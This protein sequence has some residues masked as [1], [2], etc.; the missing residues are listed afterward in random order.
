MKLINTLFVFS[1]IGLAIATTS[2]KK[3]EGP[4][5]KAQ[6]YGTVTYENGATGKVDEAPGAIIKIKYGAKESS[7][8]FDQMY[9]AFSDGSYN[10]RGLVPGDYYLTAE[11][12]DK[13]SFKHTHSGFVV[14]LNSRRSYVNVDFKLK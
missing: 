3:D 4:L 6:I 8:D 5:G 1:L 9:V 13:Y 2:C 12:I 10:I 7:L 14:T 11:F